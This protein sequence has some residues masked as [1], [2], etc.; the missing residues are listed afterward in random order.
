MAN[1]SLPALTSSYTSFVS[2]MSARFNDLAVGLD[3]AVSTNNN[4]ATGNTVP[5]NFPTGSIRWSSGNNKWQKRTVDDW[6]DLSNNYA[7]NISGN[8][9]TATALATSR[10]INNVSF[11]G[12]SDININLNNTLTFSSTGNGAVSGT[13]FN[14]NAASIIS[15]N[16]IGAPSITGAGATGANWG[17]S[18]TGNAA[19]ASNVNG[20]NSNTFTAIQTFSGSASNLAMLITD[21]AEVCSLTSTPLTGTINYDVT[22]QSVLYYTAASTNNWTINFRGSSAASINSIMATGQCLT[23]VL[24][25]QQGATAYRNIGITI[26]SNTVTPVWQGGLNPA[27]GNPNSIDVYTY[28][29]IKR[30]NNTFTVLASQT[31]FK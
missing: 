16:S 26:D 31:Q 4:P 21:A 20:A 2:E 17:I 29:I 3:P 12:T 15:Y 8:S 9:A 23:V 22:A 5:V 27:I 25:A 1:H 28:T 6:V 11:N 30:G 19:T 10:T 13:T 24:L 14:G 7:I 18:I